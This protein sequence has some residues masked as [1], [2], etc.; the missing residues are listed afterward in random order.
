M[1][2]EG[3]YLRLL[4]RIGLAFILFIASLFLIMYS[5]KFFFG[6]LDKMPWFSLMF[7]LFIICVPATVFVTV[8]VIYF[9]HTKGHPS[10]SVRI[11]SN[12]VFALILS[13]W[14]YFWILDFIMFF[15]HQYREIAH[16]NTYNLAFLAANVG[17]I[18]F[19]GIVQALTVKK[20]VDW[21][22]R[23]TEI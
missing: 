17:I 2:E 16:Y 13:A 15:K 14:A 19:I 21:M 11:F 12:I 4:G 7:A 22:E 20:E 9:F 1:Q 3:K 23:K 10:K 6:I 18:F 5:L 8:Y